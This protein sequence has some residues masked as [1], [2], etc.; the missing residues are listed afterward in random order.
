MF[1]SVLITYF[2]IKLDSLPGAV[3]LG[4]LLGFSFYVKNSGLF[5]IGLVFLYALISRFYFKNK[6]HFKLPIIS[7]LISISDYFKSI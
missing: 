2:L 3:I 7:I 4:I 6:K 5:L 1:F